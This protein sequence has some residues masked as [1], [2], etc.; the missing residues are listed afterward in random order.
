MRPEG[1]TARAG[2]R[3]TGKG[4]IF[5][6]RNP[7]L[8]GVLASDLAATVLAIPVALF[9]V[10]NQERFNGDPRTLGLFL[11]AVA[12]GGTTAG[13]LSGMVTNAARPGAVMLGAVAV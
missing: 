5:L 7:A 3:A 9:P 12:V 11:T 2:P 1:G 4:I 13:L 6:W 10:I 8:R